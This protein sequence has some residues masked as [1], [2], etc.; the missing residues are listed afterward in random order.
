MQCRPL[1]LTWLSVC[2]K[3]SGRHCSERDSRR[4]AEPWFGRIEGQRPLTWRRRVGTY[5]WEVSHAVIFISSW[6][7]LALEM[8]SRDPAYYL[9][10]SAGAAAGSRPAVARS[11]AEIAV[12]GT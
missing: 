10:G 9:C 3:R 2:L 5:H 11:A 12:G 8:V 7:K 6:G 1:C 4:G